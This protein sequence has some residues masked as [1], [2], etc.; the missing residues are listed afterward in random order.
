MSEKSTPSTRFDGF[1]NA[2][3][4]RQA[5]HTV[6]AVRFTADDGSDYPEWEEKKLGDLCESIAS[7]KTRKSTEGHVPLWG[8]SGLLGHTKEAEFEGDYLLIGR[9]GAAG[10]VRHYVGEFSASDNT[11]VI[12]PIFHIIS[13][14]WLTGFLK[15]FNLS[16]L[17]FGSSQPLITATQLKRLR[18]FTPKLQE[19]QKIASLLSSVDETITLCQRKL[20]LLTQA[21]KA[22]MQQIFS[23]QLRFKADDGSDFPEWEEK[24][25]STVASIHARIGWQN[26]RRDE[27]LSKGDYLLITGTDF[28]NGK[29]NFAT[30]HYVDQK[31]YD[32]DPHIQVD[33][34]T[35]LVTKDG[36]LGKVALVENLNL[37]ATLN[38]G[39]FAVKVTT[40]EVSP[41]FL[42]Y[43]LTAPMLLEYAAMNS[44]GGTIKHLN[45]EI[46]VAF[47]IGLP[48]LPE[49]HKIASCL[50]SADALIDQARAELEQWQEV[51]KSL[52]QQLFV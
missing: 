44:T 51:K 17:T 6:P 9:V 48:S 26:L 34:G 23:Q 39:V 24:K 31:R 18:V 10:S 3:E 11:L 47:P 1:T 40:K 4:L 41:K 29:V 50:S 35:I 22:L 32:Q 37:P 20:D 8:S 33:N 21:K 14:L 46:L 28:S 36:T 27:F 25:L 42:Y 45:Q 15:H 38:A 16:R 2:W 7:G 43:W 30:C 49:Q 19:Q 12:Q 5:S 13:S 52:L